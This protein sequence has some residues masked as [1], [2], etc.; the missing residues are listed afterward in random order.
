MANP[1]TQQFLNINP[2]APTVDLQ[3]QLAAPL[4]AN[5]AA[6]LAPQTGGLFDPVNKFVVGQ[7][8]AQAEQQMQQKENTL[9]QQELAFRKQRFEQ[10]QAAS[11]RQLLNEERKRKAALARIKNL[12]PEVI[13]KYDP[14]VL[15]KDGTLNESAIT[16][17]AAAQLVN[18]ISQ[19]KSTERRLNRE[20]M[21]SDKL[22]ARTLSRKR[23][24]ASNL[25]KVYNKAN[26]GVYGYDPSI[27]ASFAENGSPEGL[28]NYV[29]SVKQSAAAYAGKVIQDSDGQFY[30]IDRFGKRVPAND[31]MVQAAQ[32]NG[33]VIDATTGI[34]P[35]ARIADALL[36]SSINDNLSTKLFKNEKVYNR[37]FDKKVAPI[38]QTQYGVQDTQDN[39]ETVQNIRERLRTEIL[40][41]TKGNV[42]PAKTLRDTL[43][44]TGLGLYGTNVGNNVVVFDGKPINFTNINDP[45]VKKYL[46]STKNYLAGKQGVSPQDISNEV[47]LEELRRQSA[48]NLTSPG[49]EEFNPLAT[50][51]GNVS[52]AL[53][54][55]KGSVTGSLTGLAN[56]FR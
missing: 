27:A 5:T 51:G 26:K 45:K 3:G 39:P 49:S 18:L 35:S 32:M 9:R 19:D 34:A 41:S 12:S 16:P 4:S 52:A 17:E 10:E 33:S 48:L 43:R 36:N 29:R 24:E 22:Y 11:K 20:L 6:M 8:Q 55:M 42:I 2:I 37:W 46:E 21:Q 7:R 14:S 53:D 31:A 50:G 38:L 13:A 28:A 56:L 25:L 15:N 47:A 1:Y 40:A 23:N 44:K 30:A 54:T